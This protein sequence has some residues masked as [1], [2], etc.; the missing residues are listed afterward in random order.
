MSRT[1]HRNLVDDL[2]TSRAEIQANEPELS[3]EQLVVLSKETTTMDIAK[4]HVHHVLPVLC[5][6]H[7]IP[8]ISFPTVTNETD[9]SEVTFGEE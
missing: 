6:V 8:M 7:L 4:Y 2:T 9:L 3:H 1:R 5:G